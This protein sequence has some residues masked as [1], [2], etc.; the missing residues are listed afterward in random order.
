MTKTER[1]DFD[2][3][4]YHPERIFLEGKCD[5]I[6]AKLCKDCGWEKEFKERITKCK[7]QSADDLIK[8]MESLQIAENDSKEDLNSKLGD[9]DIEQKKLP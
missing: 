9:K 8:Q 1:Y 6:V 4:D 7:T 3:R 5:D 2:N